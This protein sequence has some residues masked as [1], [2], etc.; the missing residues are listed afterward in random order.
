MDT[1][2]C[3]PGFGL[4]FSSWTGDIPNT[5][6]DYWII[7][8]R[9]L[10]ITA[11]FKPLNSINYTIRATA[12]AGGSISPSGNVTVPQGSDLS[13]SIS[14]NSGYRVNNVTVDGESKGPLATYRFT[15]VTSNH[16]IS[17]NFATGVYTITARVE[18]GHGL[19]NPASQTANQGTNTSISF[20]PEVDIA[21]PVL[22]IMSRLILPDSQTGIPFRDV[23]A[24]HN[25][26]VTFRHSFPEN[27]H[28]VRES[29]Q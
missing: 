11:N 13:F 20:V 14:P 4:D 7:I 28:Y 1:S 24:D 19:V 3:Y 21:L 17:A 10:T 5:R 8:I 16:T 26:V 25:V 18:G 22:T 27:W 2:D 6:Q 9:D 29:K 23:S 12:G 15:N